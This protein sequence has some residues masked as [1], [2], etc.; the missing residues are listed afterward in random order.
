MNSIK[1]AIVAIIGGR[2]NV[3]CG[4][5]FS[6]VMEGLDNQITFGQ[7]DSFSTIFIKINS[8]DS[9][10]ATMKNVRNNVRSQFVYSFL[11][12]VGLAMSAVFI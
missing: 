2:V 7:Q 1:L 10:G 8:I 11:L 5:N 6:F 9:S 4:T 3:K 12:V